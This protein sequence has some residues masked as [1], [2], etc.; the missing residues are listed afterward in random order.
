M[1]VFG[2]IHV[3]GQNSKIHLNCK[4]TIE[5][6]YNGFTTFAPTINSVQFGDIL[7]FNCEK[8]IWDLA[9][10]SSI[11]TLPARGIAVSD[12]NAKGTRILLQ[13]FVYLSTY[14]KL[15]KTQL[16]LSDYLGKLTDN[17]PDKFGHYVQT[18]GYSTENNVFYFDFC[19]FYI[20][21]G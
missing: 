9:S 20:Q 13:G 5:N 10:A 2:D 3:Y 4:P 11:N 15:T 17:R 14:T 12:F 16:W 18:I 19:P 8:N 1:D 6:P 21:L 7:Y